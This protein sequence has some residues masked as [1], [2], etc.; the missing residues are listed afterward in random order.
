M[1]R[2]VGIVTVGA[3]MLGVGSDVAL[4]A[5]QD[6]LIF[7]VLK[8][9]AMLNEISRR[10]GNGIMTASAILTKLTL[11]DDRLMMAI[12]ALARGAGKDLVEVAL[13]TIRPGMGTLE[14]VGLVM[15][16]VLHAVN[17]IVAGQA[18]GAN[19]PD[20]QG[21]AIMIFLDMAG[22]AIGLAG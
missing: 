2:V 7:G 11:V 4:L 20:V 5:F 18:V 22:D 21:G 15:D 1:H 3:E 17:T 16:K 13:S 12:G 19:Q 14:R 10:P 9:E 8:L 6:C